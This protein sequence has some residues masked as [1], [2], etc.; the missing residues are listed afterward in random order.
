M[1]QSLA[2]DLVIFSGI[3]GTGKTTL[4]EHAARWL[5]APLFSKDEL[6]ATLRR[7]GITASMNSGWAA[8]DLLTTLAHGQL[9]RGQSAILDSVATCE[10]IRETWRSLAVESGARLRVIETVCTDNA[11]HRAR[12]AERRRSIP[13]WPELTWDDV[14]QVANRY[15]PWTDARLVLDAT[16]PLDDNLRRLRAYLVG[17]QAM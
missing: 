14:V 4:A 5:C 8:Y 9:L 10:R 3:P 16:D 7:A 17:S 15:Q 11:T 1:V 12:L 2:P 13:G 6:E